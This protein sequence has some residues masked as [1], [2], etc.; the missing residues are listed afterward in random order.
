MSPDER[1]ML[2][3]SLKL[4]LENNRML[5]DIKRSLFW[6][7]VWSWTRVIILVVPLIVGYFYLEPHFG[8]IS[9]SAKQAFELYK[10]F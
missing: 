3:R 2:E 6:N 8:S 7:R 1:E 4:S 5:R 9:D 10:S